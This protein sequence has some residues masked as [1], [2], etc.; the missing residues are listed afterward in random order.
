M[1]KHKQAVEQIQYEPP[2][3][4]EIKPVSIVNGNS[5][6]GDLGSKVIGGDET[7]AYDPKRNCFLLFRYGESRNRWLLF[8][9]NGKPLDNKNAGTIAFIKWENAQKNAAKGV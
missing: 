3:I 8:T 4:T 7:I 6:G 1:V 9:R 5:A 2:V